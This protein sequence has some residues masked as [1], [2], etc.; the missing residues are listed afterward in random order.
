MPFPNLSVKQL[1]SKI[2]EWGLEK[3][4]KLGE[5]K[6]VAKHRKWRQDEKQKESIIKRNGVLIKNSNIDR[7]EK[8]HPLNPI[9]S[10]LDF[11]IR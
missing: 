6:K 9:S 4:V 2:T 11:V 1:K 10:K 3:S 8:Q 5:M 7:W